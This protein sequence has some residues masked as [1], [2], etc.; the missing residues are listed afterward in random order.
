MTDTT[1]KPEMLLA[2]SRGRSACRDHGY[3][4]SRCPYEHGSDEARVWWSAQKDWV[5]GEWS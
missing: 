5:D 3:A 2:Y 4:A 1:E